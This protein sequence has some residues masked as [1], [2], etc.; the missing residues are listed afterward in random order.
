MLDA[1]LGAAAAVR[2]AFTFGSA[3]RGAAGG[4]AG[5]VTVG[6]WSVGV[7][8]VAGAAAVLSAIVLLIVL[9]L[10]TP[11]RD[12]PLAVTPPAEVGVGSSAD[13][14][15]PG[16]EASPN[17][18]QTGPPGPE[19]VPPVGLPAQPEN[20]TGAEAGPGTG[21]ASAAPPAPPAVPLTATYAIGDA[22]LVGYRVTVTIDNPNPEPVSSW[23]VAI[24][25]P[26]S[27]MTVREV[28]GAQVTRN[29][30]TWTFVP[31]PETPPAPAGGSVTFHFRVDAVGLG[32]APTACTINTHPC[33]AP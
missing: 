19:A 25:L 13:P 28:T 4:A 30:T 32:A 6:G 5:G 29:G 22:T 12:G 27:P 8:V 15:T 33:T 9:V 1:V 17:A 2:A 11:D 14:G 23:T 26:R 24:T 21:P 3:R 18:V 20:P 10:R 31:T 16:N 7:G